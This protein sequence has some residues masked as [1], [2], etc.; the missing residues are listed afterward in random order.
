MHPGYHRLRT[1][2]LARLGSALSHAAAPSMNTAECDAIIRVAYLPWQ[3][4]YPQQHWQL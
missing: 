1:T 4:A 3:P 2:V